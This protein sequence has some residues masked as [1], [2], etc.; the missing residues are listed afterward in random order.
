MNFHK[1]KVSF[2]LLTLIIEVIKSFGVM[3]IL[4]L[5]FRDLIL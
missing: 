2:N 1:T 3:W 5:L 4:S